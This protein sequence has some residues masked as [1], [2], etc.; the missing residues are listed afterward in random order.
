M[1]KSIHYLVSRRHLRPWLCRLM[2]AVSMLVIPACMPPAHES[3]L[4]ANL[5]REFAAEQPELWAESLPGVIRYLDY[6]PGEKKIALTLDACGSQGDSYDRP[7]VDFLIAEKISVSL[8]I[9]A[10]WID[11][12]PDIFKSLADNPLFDIQNHG[13]SHLP[14]S[15][16]GRSV[17]GLNGTANIGELVAEVETNKLKIAGLLGVEPTYYRSG[18]AYYDDVAVRV[19]HRLGEKIAGFSV[20]GDAGTTYS[21]EQIEQTLALVQSNDIIIAH[22]NHP[23]RQTAE[24]LIP[25][26]KNLKGQGFTFVTLRNAPTRYTVPEGYRYLERNLALDINQYPLGSEQHKPED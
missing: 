10:R 13:M 6:N 9:N 25:A 11:K 15:V 14:A 21:A 16:N 5:E 7:L 19:I 1:E 22:M 4:A 3:E 24:G 2:L 20:L 12:N 17:Y 8:F 26:I 23:E 18:T